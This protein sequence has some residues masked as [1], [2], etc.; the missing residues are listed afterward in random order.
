MTEEGKLRNK[1]GRTERE[2]ERGEESKGIRGREKNGDEGKVEGEGKVRDE[3]RMLSFY[4][5]YW[6]L[7]EERGLGKIAVVSLPSGV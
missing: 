4:S 3:G 5:P 6:W 2:W 1:G 7:M